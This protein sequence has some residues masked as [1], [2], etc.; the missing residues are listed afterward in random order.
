MCNV[1]NEIKKIPISKAPPDPKTSTFHDIGHQME[2]FNKFLFHSVIDF[3]KN[4][5]NAHQIPFNE[6]SGQK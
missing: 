5:K 4:S 1:H 2:T 3:E 6:E